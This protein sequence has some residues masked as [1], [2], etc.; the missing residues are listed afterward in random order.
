MQQ[1]LNYL[2]TAVRH[3]MTWKILERSMMHVVANVIFPLM[4]HSAEDEE[5][6]IADPRKYIRMKFDILEEYV[7]PVSASRNL[8]HSLCKKRRDMLQQTMAFV[9]EVLNKPQADPRAKDGVLHMVG[10][11]ADVLNKKPLYRDQMEQLIAA[12]VFPQFSCPQG[13]LRARACWTLNYFSSIEFKFPANLITATQAVLHCITVDVDLPVKVEAALCLQSLLHNQAASRD[14]VR[15][16][17]NVL[18][19]EL[20]NLIRA[21]E[22]EDVMEVLQKIVY[23]F[24]EDL[25]PIAV[26]LTNHLAHTFHSLID[27]GD[28]EED[29]KVSAAMAILSTIDTVLTMMDNPQNIRKEYARVV[30][31]GHNS[32]VNYYG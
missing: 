18:T 12:Y 32:F 14:V 19:H 3:P 24:P 9:V 6:W 15:P 28:T 11:I 1:A 20:V 26:D 29:E 30:R 7:S 27:A 2:N 10:S 13:F 17:V 21:T 5:M 22:N 4:C 16:H 25:V 31:G 23:L 8:L